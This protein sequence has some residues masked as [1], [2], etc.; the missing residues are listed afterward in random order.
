MRG[1]GVDQIPAIIFCL[2]HVN[3]ASI[4]LA[5][6]KFMPAHRARFEFMVSTH[7]SIAKLRRRCSWSHNQ[8]YERKRNKKKLFRRKN[9]R[10]QRGRVADFSHFALTF[11]SFLVHSSPLRHL[12]HHSSVNDMEI[13]TSIT[14]PHDRK[15]MHAKRPSCSLSER[16]WGVSPWAPSSKSQT[17]PRRSLEEPPKSSPLVRTNTAL[18]PIL[19][20]Y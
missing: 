1:I 14:S 7:K 19:H 12:R 4:Y 17:Y 9:G 16:A 13:N 2:T 3:N 20:S 8:D 10:E 6:R 15:T 11:G 5:A 18:G